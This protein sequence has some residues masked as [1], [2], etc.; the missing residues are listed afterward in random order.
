MGGQEVVVAKVGEAMTYPSLPQQALGALEVEV[1]VV[2]A[3]R[4]VK[5]SH[6]QSPTY[7]FL[8][9]EVVEVEVEVVLLKQHPLTLS[10]RMM[11]QCLMKQ[12]IREFWALQA[13][14]KSRLRKRN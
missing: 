12:Q 4:Q 3:K 6:P 13:K 9:E 7:Q 5:Q 11:P 10:A 2:V 1:E 14:V 8:E